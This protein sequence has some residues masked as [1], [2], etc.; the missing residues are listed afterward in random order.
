MSGTKEVEELNDLAWKFY[1]FV[2]DEQK[3][4]IARGWAK[5][6]V[7]SD[8]SPSAIDTYASLQFKLGN[9][10]EAIELESQAIELAES[11]AEDISHFQHQLK[12]FQ[13]DN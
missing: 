2:D 13:K 5:E 4:Q 8:P 11:M 7:D 12:K 10:K 3:L 6:A 9:T 1:L